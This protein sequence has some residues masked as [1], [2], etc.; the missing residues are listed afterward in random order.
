MKT[1][2]ALAVKTALT[3]AALIGVLTSPSACAGEKTSTSKP[4]SATAVSANTPS[5]T[6][7]QTADALVD[8]YD[9]IRAALAADDLPAAKKAASSL[10]TQVSAATPSI[11]ASAKKLANEGDVAAARLAFGELSEAWMAYLVAHP[12]VQKGLFAFQ[13]PMAK[14]YKKWV[15]KEK[16]MANPYMGKRM[17]QCGTATPWKV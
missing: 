3:V 8:A 5:E 11:T 12:A 6:R 17:L 13:C 7:P 14:G 2:P 16:T 1:S 10:A 4:S 9:A 15:Q